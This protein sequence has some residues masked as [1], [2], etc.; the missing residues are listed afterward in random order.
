MLAG[1]ERDR[2]LGALGALYGELGD[3]EAG[4]G[5]PAGRLAADAVGRGAFAGMLS[6]EEEGLVAEIS[7]ALAR[8]V[9][10]VAGQHPERGAPLPSAIIG[11]LGGAE[12][13]MRGEIMT[14]HSDRLAGLLPGYVYV[15]T[16]PLAGDEEALRLARRAGELVDEAKQGE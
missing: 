12:M 3:E 7:A 5:S 10:A 14:G 13:A 11:A 15:A 9:G 4:G 2:L 1:T 16:L 6:D 8:I